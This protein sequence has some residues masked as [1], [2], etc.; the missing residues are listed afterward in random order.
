MEPQETCSGAPLIIG[1]EDEDFENDMEP[2]PRDPNGL[3]QAVAPLRARPVPLL[4]FLHHVLLQ[5]DPAPL[6]CSLHAEMLLGM[7]PK[8]G[9]KQF[10]EF[11]HLF[12]D[13][14]A[15]LRVPVP[16]QLQP[17]L[18]RLRPEA[19]PEEQQRR[20]LREL[21]GGQEPELARQ[22]RDFRSKRQLGMTP[23]EPELLAL[24]SLDPGMRPQRERDLAEAML[25]RLEDV[26]LSISSDEEK[27]SA[28]LG[29]IVTYMRHL[30]VKSKGSDGKKSRT[31]FFRKKHLG[32]KKP[33]EAPGK[34]RRGFILPGGALWGRDPH[35]PDYRQGKGT[36]S[37]ADKGPP[38]DKKGPKGTERPEPGGGAPAAG[39]GSTP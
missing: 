32:G 15:L 4:A 12:L 37:E 20:I 30:G 31:H 34:P 16:L 8:E 24:E 33:E 23:G 17:E 28:I 22:L 13:K 14:G 1:A 26:H 21:R 35:Y 10:L 36:E 2:G 7:S 19:V 5:L 6:L 11:W 9:R 39:G 38:Q 25:E 18:E 3:F 27:S 29:A